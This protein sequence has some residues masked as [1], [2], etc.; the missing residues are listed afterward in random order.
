MDRTWT[1]KVVQQGGPGAVREPLFSSLETLWA[2][3]GSH[4][5]PRPFMIPARGLQTEN[6]KSLNRDLAKIQDAKIAN[7]KRWRGGRRQVDTLEC[8]RFGQPSILN[9]SLHTHACKWPVWTPRATSY[10]FAH[11]PHGPIHGTIHR[12]HRSIQAMY[13]LVQTRKARNYPWESQARPS[14]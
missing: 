3:L 9:A 1:P 12:L 8:L 5:V 11:G 2:A 10:G 6:S 14:L 13:Q 4:L 7:C